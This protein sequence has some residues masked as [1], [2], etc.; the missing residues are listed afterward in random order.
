V[1]GGK[2]CAKLKREKSWMPA[3]RNQNVNKKKRAMG[4]LLQTRWGG[5]KEKGKPLAGLVSDLRREEKQTSKLP[6][7]NEEGTPKK[8]T[9]RDGCP[10]LGK[11]KIKIKEAKERRT[12][13]AGRR[14]LTKI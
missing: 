4:K 12:G 11:E 13:T 2:D 5:K 3:K 14:G 9:C 7:K 10:P 8:E 6:L 1:G